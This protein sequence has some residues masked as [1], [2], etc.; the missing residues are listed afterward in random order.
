MTM[1]R[2]I[3]T[4]ARR[5]GLRVSVAPS[6]RWLTARGHLDPI[7]QR[8]APPDVLETLEELHR[9]LGGDRQALA[10]KNAAPL[11]PDLIIP[12]TGQIVEVDEVQH[13]TSARQSSLRWYSPTFVLG[14]SVT[15]YRSLIDSWRARADAVFTR[16][17]SPDFDF[18]GGRR[19]QRAYADALLD[20]LTPVFT[21][22][23]LL[24][25][26][27]PDSDVNAAVDRL[28][29]ATLDLD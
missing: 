3:L 18:A 10:R 19:A 1:D 23:P 12:T 16:L 29:F 14:F 25:L 5:R 17:W 9:S 2:D 7:V 4:E 22:L 24:R 20:L 26:A 28:T 13:F 27:V 15:D 11:R 21:G 6:M 8:E